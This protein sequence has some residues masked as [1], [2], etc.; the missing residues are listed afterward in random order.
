MSVHTELPSMLRNEF[1]EAV[2]SVRLAEAFI[3]KVR[4]LLLILK[5]LRQPTKSVNFHTL[6]SKSFSLFAYLSNSFV[7]LSVILRGCEI[8][9]AFYDTMR[10]IT[11]PV[12]LLSHN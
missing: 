11:P 3:D 8:T 4:E 5:N 10:K 6:F 1:T 7:I 9:N 12:S 2:T